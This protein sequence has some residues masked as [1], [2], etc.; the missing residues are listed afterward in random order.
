MYAYQV[1]FLCF[2]DVSQYFLLKKINAVLPMLTVPAHVPNNHRHLYYEFWV[3]AR[4]VQNTNRYTWVQTGTIIP[5]NSELWAE[6]SPV[7]STQ[8]STNPCTGVELLLT[9]KLAA[10]S[11]WYRKRPMC[12]PK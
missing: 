8:S 3:G 5:N 4:D 7:P 9:R 1:C 2:P 6:N 10:D 12:G 11:C